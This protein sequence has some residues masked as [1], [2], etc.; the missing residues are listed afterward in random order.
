MTCCINNVILMYVHISV[1]VYVNLLKYNEIFIKTLK[2]NT[3][4][5]NG[6]VNSSDKCVY[7]KFIIYLVDSWYIQHIF[8]NITNNSFI[9]KR[10]QIIGLAV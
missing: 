8:L 6:C 4:S 3:F 10:K 9:I 1:C 7:E 5:Y 2:Y